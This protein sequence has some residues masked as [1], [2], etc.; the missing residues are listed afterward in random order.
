M[1]PAMGFLSPDRRGRYWSSLNADAAPSPAATTGS[2]RSRAG[3]RNECREPRGRE[4]LPA[5]GQS[6][7]RSRLAGSTE[8]ARSERAFSSPG[9]VLGGQTSHARA[10]GMSLE[11]CAVLV[12]VCLTASAT[13]C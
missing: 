13:D 2:S 6:L 11:A 4:L 7:T 10:C 12:R 3:T 8:K 1:T 9:G 5:R